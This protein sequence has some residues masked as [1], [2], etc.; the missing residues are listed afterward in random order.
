MMISRTAGTGVRVLLSAAAACASLLAT[1]SCQS[2]PSDVFIQTPGEQEQIQ[3]DAAE[4]RLLE[5]R[6]SPDVAAAAALKAE[7]DKTAE[8]PSLSRQ[9]K[10]RVTSMRAEAALLAASPTEAKALADQAAAISDTEEALWYVRAAVEQDPDR[11]LAILDEG[12]KKAE[13]KFRLLCERG[14]TL[15]KAG[16]Y[17][18]A[19]QDLDEGLRGLDYRYIE[20]YGKDRDRAF[21]LAEAA[22]VTGTVKPPEQAAN[23]ES[24]LTLR[25]MV[26]QGFSETRLISS[27]S[28][29]PKPTLETALQALKDARLLLSPDAPADSP[30]ARKDIAFFL[31]G[32]VARTERNPRLLEKY[33]TKYTVSPVPDVAMDTPYFD[34]VLGVVEREIMDLPDGLNFKPDA[35]VTGLEYLGML[36]KLKKQYR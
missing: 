14:E 16:R 31:W 2:T 33:R 8:K 27:L 13:R 3:L 34:S 7:L 32:I 15:F 36:S 1:A 17:A 23:L 5:L 18:E 10:A 21:T 20:V 26:E 6:I 29:D 22:K 12:I 35:E 4:I 24:A 28:S 30:V 19:A 11:R 25:A 9:L